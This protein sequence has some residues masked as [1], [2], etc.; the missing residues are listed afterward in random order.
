MYKPCKPAKNPDKHDGETLI[1]N[2]LGR[3]PS[4]W[5]KPAKAAAMSA[6]FSASFLGFQIKTY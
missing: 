4:H 6:V 2:P 3:L 5:V 1:I